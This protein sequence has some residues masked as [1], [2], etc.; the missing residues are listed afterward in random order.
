LLKGKKSLR[1]EGLPRLTTHSTGR[2]D[3]I[4]FIVVF[5]GLLECFSR[6]AGYFGRSATRGFLIVASM[7][8]TPADVDPLYVERK[9]W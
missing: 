5:S 2:A 6:R 1:C 4:S 9:E 8:A 3:S 7:V